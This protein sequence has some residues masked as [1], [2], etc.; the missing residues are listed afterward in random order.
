MRRGAPLLI[1]GALSAGLI[2]GAAKKDVAVKGMSLN[3]GATATTIAF[4]QFLSDRGIIRDGA[5]TIEATMKCTGTANG[6][7]VSCESRGLSH[8]EIKKM[9]FGAVLGLPMS[10][11]LH[12][13][14]CF[15]R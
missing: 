6:G 5:C 10:A 9:G 7:K 1:V 13:A 4:R 15:G 11:P 2:T 14:R 12:I 8:A 3:V